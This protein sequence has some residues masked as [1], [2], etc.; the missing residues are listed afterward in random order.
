MGRAGAGVFAQA[1]PLQELGNSIVRTLGMFNF[2]GDWNPRHNIPGMPMLGWPIS[3]LFAIGF[4]KE[5]WHWLSRKHGH[6]SPVHT[7]LFSW[8]FI[9]LLPGFLSTEAPHALRA[10]GV[11]PIA[12]IFAA[13]GLWVLF[14]AT[15]EWEIVHH[16]WK[17]RGHSQLI[18]PM[19][20]ILALLGA[21]GFY[22]YNRY[23][24]IF[25]KAEI[26]QG[27]FAQNYYD[28]AQQINTLPVSVKKYVIV[29]ADGIEAYGLPVPAETVMFLTDTPTPALQ[30]AKNVIYL[31]KPAAQG[32]H[33]DQRARIFH[34]Q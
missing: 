4:L 1:H 11:V 8:F 27:A 7:L 6:F 5:L 19:L 15:E 24:N 22:E 32:Y 3:I 29:D 13:R 30:K 34:I 14:H 23:F 16:P 26:T 17:G 9:M 20:A 25:A 18:G 2:M 21:I 31:T 33:F 12:M 28:I 10:L